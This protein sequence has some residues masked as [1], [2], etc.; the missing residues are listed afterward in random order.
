MQNC[1]FQNLFPRNIRKKSPSK[2][3]N[4]KWGKSNT[5]K[6]EKN[7]DSHAKRRRKKIKRLLEEGSLKE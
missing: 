4:E 3:S 7:P 2:I 1:L 5:A 6:K